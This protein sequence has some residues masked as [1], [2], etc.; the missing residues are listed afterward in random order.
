MR[1]PRFTLRSLLLLVVFVALVL[2]LVVQ[3]VEIDRLHRRM[4]AAQHRGEDSRRR[5]EAQARRAEMARQLRR[6][7]AANAAAPANDGK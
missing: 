1:L 7:E 2:G 6:L 4:L 3:Q 5:A